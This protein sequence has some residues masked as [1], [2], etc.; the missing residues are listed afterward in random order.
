MRLRSA[1]RPQGALIGGVLGLAAA[2]SCAVPAAQGTAGHTD[3]VVTA[4]PAAAASDTWHRAWHAEDVFPDPTT[5][6]T[7]CR[8]SARLTA[9][10]SLLRATFA[11]DGPGPGY[12]LLHASIA[13]PVAPHSLEVLPTSSLPLTFSGSR[14]I[15]V[16]GRAEV[17]SDAVALP[18]AAGSD[19]L[20][21]IT[22]S[23]GDAYRKGGF[24]EPGACTPT[25]LPG[26]A[27]AP[28]S[29]FSGRSHVRWLRSLLVDG[30]PVR[31][32]VALG[33]SLT[34]GPESPT[35][36]YER[37]SDQLVAPGV[38]VANAGVGGGA[39][40]RLGMFGTDLGT[41][42]GRDLL[43]GPE[44]PGAR[45][46]YE[47]PQPHVDDLIVMLGTNDLGYGQSAEQVI[48]AMNTVVADATS[49]G[50]QL[51]FCTLL[52]RGAP[53]DSVVEQRRLAI[54]AALLGGRFRPFGVKV[55]DTGSVVADPTAPNQ[56]APAFDAGDHLHI[57]A[58]GARRVGI[59]VR[60]A[61][62]ASAERSS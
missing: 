14:S 4:I 59:V 57:D 24:V 6:T 62:T 36:T 34:E 51:W 58:D 10:G 42:R 49:S 5:T 11:S 29:S 38:A 60:R 12:R 30:P 45:S 8:Y 43:R 46:G 44:V 16:A 3:A 47:V 13:R 18:V 39:L 54:N 27:T 56:L 17:M 40:S 26:A 48:A 61:L 32:V 20:V 52:P 50:T 28:A 25:D 53:R 15:A 7:T 37:W 35:F 19:V 2:A 31:S 9:T 55:I 1:S 33:D 41:A 21:T 23:A 22:A